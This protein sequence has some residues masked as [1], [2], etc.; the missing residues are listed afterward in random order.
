MRASPPGDV[1]CC[2]RLGV[3]ASGQ[4]HQ[5]AVALLRQVDADLARDLDTL[6][7]IRTKAGYGAQPVNAVE[8]RRAQRAASR[9]VQAAQEADR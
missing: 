7:R 5:E 1:L 3:H 8:R 6:L 9:L 2:A 4:Q